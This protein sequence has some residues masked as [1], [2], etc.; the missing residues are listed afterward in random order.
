MNTQDG[1]LRFRCFA[2][3]NGFSWSWRY[4]T[5]PVLDGVH[6]PPIRSDLQ[7]PPAL[8]HYLSPTRFIMSFSLSVV[9]LVSL[10]PLSSLNLPPTLFCFPRLAMRF[11]SLSFRP[12]AAGLDWTALYGIGIG[13]DH[14]WLSGIHRS[15]RLVSLPKCCSISD[16]SW[17]V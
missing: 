3:P 15:V 13:Q 2:Q 8:P 1:M 16:F 9:L 14:W 10:L 7:P 12:V 5:L 4:P 6:P 11:I 17:Q